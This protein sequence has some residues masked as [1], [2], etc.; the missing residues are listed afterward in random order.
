MLDEFEDRRGSL[1]FP[2]LIDTTWE[3]RQCDVRWK[4]PN[5]SV[6]WVCS[7]MIAVKYCDSI[8]IPKGTHTEH[9]P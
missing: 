3:C 4:G 7:S 8:I 6:C 5:N 9:F 1:P 2:R